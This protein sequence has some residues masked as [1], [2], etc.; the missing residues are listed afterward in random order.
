MAE[1]ALRKHQ[2]GEER[3]DCH[4]QSEH[5][6][7]PG[8]ANARDDNCER[9]RL[10]AAAGRHQPEERWQEQPAR[11]GDGADR[12][13]CLQERH[14][15]RRH[16]HLARKDRNEEQQDDDREVLQ[17]Q[18][19]DVQ[20]PVRRGQLVPLGHPLQHDGRARQ[21]DEQTGEHSELW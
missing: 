2:P 15:H 12:D 6:S 16:R 9:K 14:R 11:S 18:D 20:P 13:E 10:A 8:G 21:R 19:P 5:R 3:A 7:Q 4:R 17:Q 1:L